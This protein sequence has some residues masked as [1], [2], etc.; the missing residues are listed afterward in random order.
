MRE[1]V[2]LLGGTIE[3]RSAPGAGVQL[4]VELPVAAG[5]EPT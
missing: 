4:H 3:L 1:R 5:S 2:E